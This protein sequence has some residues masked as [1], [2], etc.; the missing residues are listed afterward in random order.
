MGPSRWAI[1]VVLSGQASRIRDAKLACV[2]YIY[3]MHKQALKML[4]STTE[5][6]E[7]CL[8]WDGAAEGN[9]YGRVTYQGKHYAAHRLMYMLVHDTAL[10]PSEFVCHS[11][12]NPPCINPDHLWLGDNSSNMKD[13]WGKGRLK[14]PH[15]A[16]GSHNKLPE[17][18][19]LE[20]V[21]AF[22]PGRGTLALAQRY[23]VT[24][25]TIRNIVKRRSGMKKEGLAKAS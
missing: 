14:I 10:L 22:T 12:D 7:G 2:W 6:D 18:Q 8:F 19:E 13:A 1:V 25:Q 9:G 11:C 3:A 5:R 15:G 23:R 16:G 24:P 21:S 17:W 4:L 20:I